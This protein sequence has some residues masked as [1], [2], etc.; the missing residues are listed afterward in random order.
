MDCRIARGFLR[1][2]TRSISTYHILWFLNILPQKGIEIVA[3]ELVLHEVSWSISFFRLFPDWNRHRNIPQF[4]ELYWLTF[5]GCLGSGNGFQIL[6]PVIKKWFNKSWHIST[7][8]NTTNFFLIIFKLM[9]QSDMVILS[10]PA[11]WTFFPRIHIL[12]FLREATQNYQIRLL[13]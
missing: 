6:F 11:K 12:I 10:C 1:S 3:N 7:T 13:Y 4:H 8:P 9:Q 2:K 5:D